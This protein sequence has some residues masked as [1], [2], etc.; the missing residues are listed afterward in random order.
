MVF[1][2]EA[3]GDILQFVQ[4]KTVDYT[5]GSTKSTYSFNFLRIV[6]LSKKI[7]E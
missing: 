7:G 4:Y 3:L 5:T 2:R 1:K 6:D